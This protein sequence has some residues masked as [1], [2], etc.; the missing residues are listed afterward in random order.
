MV[1]YETTLLLHGKYAARETQLL[2]REAAKVIT[3]RDG[4]VLRILD[5]GWRHTAQ[6]VLKKRVGYFF[7]GRW[8]CMT[9]GAHPDAVRD[10]RDVFQHNTGVLRH[11]TVKIRNPFDMYMPRSTFYPT[12]QRSSEF[13]TPPLTHHRP[14]YE[15]R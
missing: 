13:M 5:M 4:S 2:I 3:E 9:W 11:I 6:P 1:F 8:Y 14:V 7:Y 15:E 12:L 10:L